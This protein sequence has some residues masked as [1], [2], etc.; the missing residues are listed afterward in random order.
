M[1]CYFAGNVVLCMLIK[2]QYVSIRSN[3][4][5]MSTTA[6]IIVCL[7]LRSVSA[8]IRLSKRTVIN[9][10][11]S[12]CSHGTQTNKQYILLTLFISRNL[13]ILHASDVYRLQKRLIF[14]NCI[15]LYLYSLLQTPFA[16]ILLL[17]SCVN[18]KLNTSV[19]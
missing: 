16:K 13:C 5:Y 6:Y 8:E 15:I 14:T 7:Q 10:S 11:F 3:A 9:D 2:P 1:L 4:P 19:F 12:L 17:V 18:F